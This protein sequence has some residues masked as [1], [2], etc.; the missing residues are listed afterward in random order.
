MNTPPVV[1][2]HVE[3]AQHN[4][5]E[6]RRPFRFEAYCNHG[7]CSEADQGDKDTRYAPLATESEANE[8]EDEE[9]TACQ[10]ET[11]GEIW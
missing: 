10:K 1:D 6:R 4:D 5:E 8:E 2:E 9:Y 3:N 7:A 11:V